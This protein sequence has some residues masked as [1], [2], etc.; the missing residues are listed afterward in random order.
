MKLKS[1]HIRAA[2][3]LAGWSQADL[4]ARADLGEPTIAKLETGETESANARTYDKIEKAFFNVGILFTR[5]GVEENRSTIRELTGDDFFD[6]VLDD[7]YATLLDTKGAEILTIGGDD[8]HN[9]PEVVA[10]LRKLGHAGIRSRDI[11]EEGNMFLMG[12][13][14]RYRW[15]PKE[16]F[17]N[18]V[19][20]IYGDK[21][22]LDFGD[23]GLMIHNHEVAEV[24]RNIFNLLWQT[25]PELTIESTADVRI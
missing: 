24:Q 19:T 21:V 12:P 4:A 13:V 3:A 15:M 23:R 25:L 17:K 11:V 10:R 16:F 8:R 20:V 14:A 7:A 6:E 1:N 5:N 2:R 18:H 9:T 22:V